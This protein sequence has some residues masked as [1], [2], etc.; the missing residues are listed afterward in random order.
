MN[1][2]INRFID[3]RREAFTKFVMNDDWESLKKYCRKYKIQIPE[4]RTIAAVG[5]YKAAVACTDVSWEVRVKA[6]EKCVE[7]GFSP[8]IESV[9]GE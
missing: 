1:D 3:D 6:M 2:T 7:L 4:D 5:F 8:M 9:V